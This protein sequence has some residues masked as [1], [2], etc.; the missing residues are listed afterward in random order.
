MSLGGERLYRE[1]QRPKQAQPAGFRTEKRV[2]LE[3]LGGPWKK[4]VA[5]SIG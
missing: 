2:V 5:K 3:R 1:A 4:S